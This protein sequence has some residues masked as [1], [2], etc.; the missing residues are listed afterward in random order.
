MSVTIDGQKVKEKTEVKYFGANIDKKLTFQSEVKNI[1]RCL[2][3]G[4]KSVYTLRNCVP[5]SFKKNT[6]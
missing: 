5:E 4:I 6:D 1:L 3:E 2:T